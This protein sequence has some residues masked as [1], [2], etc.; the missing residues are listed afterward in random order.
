M[1]RVIKIAALLVVI[2]GVIVGVAALLHGHTIDILNPQGEVAVKERNLIVFTLLLSLV[3]V[4]PVFTLLI[5]F[6]LRY[7]ESNT[8]KAPYRP[9]WDNNKYLEIIWWGIP[10]II[11][12][13]LGTITW[14]TSHQLDPYK[15][16]DSNVPALNVQVVA[17][18]WKWLFIYPDQHIASVN[19]LPIPEKTPVNF[20]ITSDAPMNSFWIPSLGGQ[21][22]AMSGMSTKLSLI[23]NTTG[24]FKG[25]SA[26]ISGAG[27][28]DMHFIARSQSKADFDMWVKTVQSSSKQ[29]DMTSYGNLAK[30]AT[31]AQPVFFKLNDSA[32]YDKIVMKYMMPAAQQESAQS[33]EK[34]MNTNNVDTSNGGAR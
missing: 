32:L 10:C 26:N 20:S 33:T 19:L 11:I 5:V 31:V 17:L 1:K 23:A 7:R 2:L 6:S 14:T 15:K 22:Y 12:L 4:V 9:N 18:Q 28:A 8:K 29:L 25:S 27:F 16:L 34:S 24:D 21:V 30:P 13:I 3:V